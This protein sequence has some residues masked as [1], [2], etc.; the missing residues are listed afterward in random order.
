MDEN[1]S[2]EQDHAPVVALIAVGNMGSWV[3]RRLTGHGVE[4]R[5][6]LTGR[7]QASVERA[8]QANMRLMDDDAAL[9]AGADFVFSVVPPDAVLELAERLSPVL[10]NATHK[11][12]YVDCNAVDSD[13]IR[14]VA[15]IISATGCEMID[16]GIF[17]AAPNDDSA[18][19]S[20]YAS[21]PQAPQL[22]VLNDFGLEIAVLDAPIG[23]ASALKCSFAG[24]S[25][26]VTALCIATA[27]TALDAGV[28]KEFAHEVAHRMPQM[29]THMQKLMPQSFPKSKRWGKEMQQIATEF[30]GVTGG[31]DIYTGA[32]G[33]Y[34]D[35][36]AS[37]QAD[38]PG[39]T[40]A[41]ALQELL[42]LLT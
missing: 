7:S 35:I 4:V 41:D 28:D 14:N 36:A 16:A 6:V 23:S 17:G 38:K 29:A 10:S 26:G 9:I 21:G 8:H 42:D 32:G 30:K 33:V 27:L 25:K 20:F 37:M 3:A 12:V 13:T 31:E 18:G 2:H 24:L 11:P 15:E 5:T 1:S 39:H 34:A 19:P 40:K 22:T